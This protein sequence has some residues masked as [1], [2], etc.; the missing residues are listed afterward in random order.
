MSK[1]SE[2]QTTSLV[3]QNVED[4]SKDIEELADDSL[5]SY[6]DEFINSNYISSAKIAD[7]VSLSNEL[8][9]YYYPTGIEVNVID[10]NGLRNGIGGPANLCKRRRAV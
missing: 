7:T 9:A 1:R 6:I 5:L 2:T 10:L 3:R 8:N 4:V